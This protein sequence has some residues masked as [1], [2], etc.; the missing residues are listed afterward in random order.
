MIAVLS[1]TTRA[2]DAYVVR[3]GQRERLLF[4]IG[5]LRD[6]DSDD[7]RVLRALV[8]TQHGAAHDPGQSLYEFAY[9][10][11]SKT[12]THLVA[13]MR[14]DD[15]F[16][17]VARLVGAGLLQRL[18]SEA[19]DGPSKHPAYLLQNVVHRLFDWLERY[20]GFRR[21]LILMRLRGLLRELAP[22]F[23]LRRKVRATIST[24]IAFAESTAPI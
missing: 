14:M 22:R 10:R 11:T 17:R 1:R 7:I 16:F 5:L 23:A 3:T 6:L 4:F 2:R 15:M 20:G 19:P 21:T 24:A 12:L 9:E 8:A 18:E 13:P